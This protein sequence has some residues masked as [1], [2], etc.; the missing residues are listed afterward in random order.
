[1]GERMFYRIAMPGLSPGQ[2]RAMARVLQRAADRFEERA[3]GIDLRVARWRKS[4][5]DDASPVIAQ[6]LHGVARDLRS[7]A[8][9]C[10]GGQ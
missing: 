10:L 1:M 3:R 9:R 4:R 7:W 2:R 5:P 8:T 6:T